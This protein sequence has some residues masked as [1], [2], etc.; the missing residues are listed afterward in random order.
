M[1]AVPPPSAA[2][3]HISMSLLSR[4]S[5]FLLIFVS[6]EPIANCP[7]KM[8]DLQKDYPWTKAPLIAGAPMRKIALA[9]L[10]VE[11]SNGGGLGFIG[12]GSDADD[13]A[14]LLEETR[15]LQSKAS[16]LKEVR[17]ILPVGVGF[18]LWAGDKLLEAALPVL[19]KYHPAAVWLYAAHETKDLVR[20]TTEVRRVSPT[21]KI[22]I[23][24]G[25][26]REAVEY[27]QACQP[28]VLVVQGQDAGGHGL[29]KAAGIM[30]LFPE[31]DDAITEACK[32][33]SI[34]KP[35]MIATGGLMDGRGLAAALALGASGVC[36]GTRYLASHEAKIMK[37]YGQA[38]VEA[39]DGGQT[40]ARTK[41]YD[42]LRGTT[43]WPDRFGG[44]GV[45]N[46]SFDDHA[47]GMSFEENKRLHD[48]ALEQ[49]DEGWISNNRL[50]TYAGTGVGLVKGVKGAAD[51]T[52]EVREDALSI[53]RG[54]L[55][56]I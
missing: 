20:W 2:N 7:F 36:L 16:D 15:S 41:L 1:D 33:H 10:A 31:V 25:N 34:R 14:D 8:D 28:D 29:I 4:S 26:V 44:R 27:T 49:G 54:N 6:S 47:S 17:D 42:A 9:S 48:E 19:E 3:S 12:A 21:T 37:G 32:Q 50:T 13:L 40:T 18:L 38:V 55:S 24:I 45:L 30:P 23:Q 43:D 5:L 22:W 52:T 46:N 11:I 39:A 51:I 53:L 35:A 56:K